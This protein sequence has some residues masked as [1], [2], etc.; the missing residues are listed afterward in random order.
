MA[1]ILTLLPTRWRLMALLFAALC[2]VLATWTG[3]HRWDALRDHKIHNDIISLEKRLETKDDV[4]KRRRMVEALDD[5]ELVR[6]SIK[7]L[8]GDGTAATAAFHR[9]RAKPAQ[10]LSTSH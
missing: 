4:E 6:D 1:W 2:V 5:C 8:S 7:R 10:D 9:C 3:W